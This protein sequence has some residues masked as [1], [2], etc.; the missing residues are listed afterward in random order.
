[1]KWCS[2]AVHKA[3]AVSVQG[4]F[5]PQDFTLSKE[6]KIGSTDTQLEKICSYPCISECSQKQK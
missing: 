1:M 3:L 6:R 5:L 4:L 2:K